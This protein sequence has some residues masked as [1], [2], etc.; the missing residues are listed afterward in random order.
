M[1]KVAL[2]TNWYEPFNVLVERFGDQTPAMNNNVYKD[3]E[4]VDPEHTSTYDAAFVLNMTDQPVHC[5]DDMIF[6]LILEPPEL[7][8]NSWEFIADAKAPNRWHNAYKEQSITLPHP[9]EERNARMFFFTSG[10]K[11][12]QAL[13]LGLAQTKPTDLLPSQKTK[14]CSMICSDK[15]L[16]YWHHRRRD[17]LAALLSSNLPIDFY[18][19]GM[20]TTV[21]HRVKGEIPEGKKC[22]AL[23]DYRFVIDFE[24]SEY[25]AIT[26]KMFDPLFNGC[27]PIT[28][29]TGAA[30]VF[31]EGSFEW[32][33]FDQG[34]SEIVK[35]IAH[36]ISQPQGT[37]YDDPV[38]EAR[39]LL[40][41]GP[42][43]IC[44]WIYQRIKNG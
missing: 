30:K 27:V 12:E 42:I 43:N 40:L 4:F 3:L 18:G 41:E 24:N 8:N 29:S 9:Q 33:N 5:E 2:F 38:N 20:Q 13:G 44:E 39:N 25:D 35:Q 15:L 37:G 19:R 14:I 21:D 34:V 6:T 10:T 28:N 23:T 7:L 32:I 36:I 17:V 26:D 1:I 16:T 11:Y 22:N 31:P